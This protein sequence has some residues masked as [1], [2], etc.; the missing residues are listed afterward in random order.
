MMK[1][2]IT[3]ELE[4]LDVI[5]SGEEVDLFESRLRDWLTEEIKRYPHLYGMVKR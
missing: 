5:Y 3:I 4:I 1:K 2:K